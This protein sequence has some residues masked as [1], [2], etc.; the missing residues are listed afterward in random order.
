MSLI[1]TLLY[2]AHKQT[3]E[4][5]QEHSIN[6]AGANN[7][8]IYSQKRHL[9]DLAFTTKAQLG[10]PVIDLLCENLKRWLVA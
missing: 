10:K 1:K 4:G 7:R 9:T 2:C 8:F 6:I 5:L 3:G